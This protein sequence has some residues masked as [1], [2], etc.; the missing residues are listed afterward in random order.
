M[1]FQKLVKLIKNPNTMSYCRWSSDDFGCDIYAYQSE[2]GYEIH[3]ATN[4]VQ[5]DIPK[6][7]LPTDFEDKEQLQKCVDAHKAQM[8]FL[9]TCERREIGLP[10]DGESFMVETLEEFR[11]KLL[12]LRQMGYNFPD[13]VF[14]R[15]EEE[16]TTP[17]ST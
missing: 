8:K 1:G 10:E 16:L 12:Q 5:G 13:Y 14:E 6:I 9:E 2:F 17:E 15:I 11:D 3:V 4:R 7:V